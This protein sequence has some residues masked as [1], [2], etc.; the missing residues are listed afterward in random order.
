MS[1][2]IHTTAFSAPDI[3]NAKRLRRRF[4]AVDTAQ[5]ALTALKVR[6][7]QL[8]I[9]HGQD[10]SRDPLYLDNLHRHE[11]QLDAALAA[12]Q[13]DDAELAGE[14]ALLHQRHELANEI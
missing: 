2:T 7:A 11:A 6:E 1:D 10:L 3:K 9:V 14:V 5:A 8:A 13:F 4:M 12:A